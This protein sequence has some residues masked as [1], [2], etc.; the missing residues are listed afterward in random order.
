M[1]HLEVLREKVNRLREEIAEIQH[2]NNRTQ[3]Y[4]KNDPKAQLAHI[5]RQ[6]RL[7]AIQ[8]ELVQIAALGPK[9]RLIEE[10]KAK[11]RFRL[12]LKRAA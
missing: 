5:K 11:H 3:L 4:G 2:F 12:H 1:D 10:M 7:Q 8:R 6:E 9:I